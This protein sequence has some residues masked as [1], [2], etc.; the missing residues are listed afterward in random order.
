MNT[1]N[2]ETIKNRAKRLAN[3]AVRIWQAPSL[4]PEVLAT[5]EFGVSSRTKSYT[6]RDHRHLL[7]GSS[8]RQLFEEFRKEVLAIDPCVSEEFLKQYVAYKAETNFVDVVPQAS[9]MRMVLNL[10]FHELNDPRGMAEDVTNLGRWGNGDA[11]IRV[12]SPDD[13]PYVL[14]LV[15]QAFERQMDH[16]EEQD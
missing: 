3:M 14:G 5:Y 12:S 13:L 1:W 8:T 6:I 4:S 10:K 15:R 11:E 16:G 7:D 2:E 9:R